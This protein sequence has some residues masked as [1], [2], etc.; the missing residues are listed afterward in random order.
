MRT[1]GVV[2]ISKWGRL[3]VTSPRA[4]GRGY[5][6]RDTLAHEYI[7]L[8]V[9]HNTHDQTPVWLQEGIARYLDNRWEYG[10]DHFHLDP[11]AEGH[12]A[13]AV[14]NELE[15]D[16]CKSPPPLRARQSPTLQDGTANPDYTPDLHD[17]FCFLSL[18]D[19]HPSVALL[20]SAKYASLAYTQ[21]STMVQYTMDQGGQRVLRDVLAR[22]DD[23]AS[24][25]QALA[26]AA[27]FA[28]YGALSYAWRQHIL[29]LDL[30]ERELAELGTTLDG[31]DALAGDPVMTERAD[32]VRRM[33][34]GDLLRERGHAKAALVEYEQA[35]P[36]EADQLSPLLAAR[37]AQAHLDLGAL[38]AARLELESSLAFFPEM[39]ISHKILGAVSVA[40]GRLAD[41]IAEY[42]EAE[43]LDPFDVEVQEDLASLLARQG[44]PERAARHARYASILKTGGE[45]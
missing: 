35:R 30:V 36:E 17:P 19:M 10:E 26:Q 14:R 32:L 39:P 25:D 2:A 22:I 13:T 27:G 18:D 44:Q 15:L 11:R 24:P 23:G 4:L 16:Y 33:R 20:P 34:L 38:D 9:S 7:H 37:M 45:G 21:V 29:G 6:W 5:G 31:G 1:T 8:V 43:R 40:Q 3:L 28:D 42:T 41:A 12:L